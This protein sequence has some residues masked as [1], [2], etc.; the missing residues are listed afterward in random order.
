MDCDCRGYECLGGVREGR[1]PTC[2]EE[3]VPKGLE[4]CGEAEEY[5]CG[6]WA[7]LGELG[8]HCDFCGSVVMGW[9]GL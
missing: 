5:V 6:D 3:E 8:M 7:C 1:V 4:G 2:R 9:L